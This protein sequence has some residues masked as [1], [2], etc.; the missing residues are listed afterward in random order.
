MHI[1]SRSKQK[2]PNTQTMPLLFAQIPHTLLPLHHHQIMPKSMIMSWDYI[3]RIQ[4]PILHQTTNSTFCRFIRLR[5]TN[6][7]APMRSAVSRLETSSTGWTRI[8]FGSET[9]H[10]FSTCFLFIFGFWVLICEIVFCVLCVCVCVCV[11]F[12]FF[13]YAV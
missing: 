2:I 13:G 4:F 10:H 6:P 5:R 7:L 9:P 12:F 1:P 8:I 11:F 3:D